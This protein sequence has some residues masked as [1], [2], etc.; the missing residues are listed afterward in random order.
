MVYVGFKGPAY[1]WF[2]AHTATPG[3]EHV[4]SIDFEMA[5]RFLPE[6][7]Y[8]LE[9]EF[10]YIQ[11]P[12]PSDVE[13]AQGKLTGIAAAVPAPVIVPSDQPSPLLIP[14]PPPSPVKWFSALPGPTSSS[15]Q[16]PPPSP[17]QV[18][19]RASTPNSEVSSVDSRPRRRKGEC[20]PHHRRNHTTITDALIIKWVDVYG[21][22]WRDL[23]RSLGGRAEGW[24][25][26]MVRNRYIRL[27][28]AINGTPYKRRSRTPNF[29][30]P[31]V[32]MEKWT[33]AEDS[34]LTK[35]VTQYS[36]YEPAVRQ[37]SWRSIAKHFKGV[38]TQQ[39]IRNR[40]SRLG[41]RDPLFITATAMAG[42]S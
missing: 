17:T 36:K 24:S 10:E 34:L 32:P 23:T 8:D 2:I 37:V 40:A 30:K 42:S 1:M 22:T 38:R 39:A 25:D 28:E 13:H 31:D 11:L 20:T 18:S 14:P 27:T 21:P 6:Q 35:L 15:P 4:I 26:D 16:P 29:K 33:P 19:S 7:D 9:P 3:S 5:L 41:L 12:L